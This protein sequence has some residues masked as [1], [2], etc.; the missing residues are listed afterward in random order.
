MSG[1]HTHDQTLSLFSLQEIG[2][3]LKIDKQNHE[4]VEFRIYG[5]SGRFSSD[6]IA[7]ENYAKVSEVRV[8]FGE[9]IQSLLRQY[10]SW[11]RD[12][13]MCERVNVKYSD[14]S[15]KISSLLFQFY[16]VRSSLYYFI[17]SASRIYGY[18]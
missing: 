3:N 16:S 12:Y 8:T 2:V 15:D 18:H 5:N 17:V 10:T 14:N 1:S 6:L 7:N 4:V 13:A 9:K 11:I